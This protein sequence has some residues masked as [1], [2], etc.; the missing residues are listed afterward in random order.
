MILSGNALS[1][2]IARRL[3]SIAGVLIILTGAVAATVTWFEEKRGIEER[4]TQLAAS[5]AASLAQTIWLVDVSQMQ[6]QLKGIA[7]FPGVSH[8]AVHTF[9]GQSFRS[10]HEAGD[11]GD[12]FAQ[13]TVPLLH[14]EQ[15]IGRLEL[16]ISRSALI[17]RVGSRLWQIILAQL[18]LLALDAA[19]LFYFVRRDASLP[20]K[21][22]AGQLHNFKPDAPALTLPEDRRQQADEL[23]DLAASFN[24]MQATIS[25]KIDD[26]RRL[27]REL[28]ASH[29]RLEDLAANRQRRLNYL[30]GFGQ[31]VLHM[32]S[33]FI[34][35]PLEA[36]EPEV[37]R[38]LHEVAD[39]I[40][41]DCVV[42]VE[43]DAQGYQRLRA[44]T[45]AR[46]EALAAADETAIAAFGHW[47]S[48]RLH[49]RQAMHHEALSALQGEEARRHAPLTALAVEAIFSVP[50][51]ARGRSHGLLICAS[52]GR[53]RV[54]QEQELDLLELV[55][56]ITASALMQRD[57]LRDLDASHRKL[58]E[59]NRDL[60]QLARTDSLTGLPNRREFNDA[61][62]RE[63]ARSLRSH[64]PLSL[65]LVDLDYFKAYNDSLGHAEGDVCLSAFAALL[66]SISRRPADLPVRLGGEEFGLLLPATDI[67]G[68]EERGFAL[69]KALAQLGLRHPASPLGT[70]LTASIGIAQFD[71]RRHPRFDD[72]YAEADAALYAA[73]AGG[74]DCI[75]AGVP[76]RRVS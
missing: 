44:C 68:A 76:P 26:E 5:H 42:I 67:R 53:P 6:E 19:V 3:A 64:E 29:D 15:A 61:W 60:E 50:L 69:Q 28:A 25:R 59:A 12:S 62:Q 10:E 18:L 36:F 45:A 30:E 70:M 17:Q 11:R 27:R 63:M 52:F 9:I 65:L 32:S 14:E 43:A 7:R 39:H 31:L 13:L 20:I 16:G 72:L 1:Q 54:W 46:N 37:E 41:V 23:A 55:G 40:A 48:L 38:R 47:V 75:M 24:R 58:E 35:L 49:S 8:V 2:R 21:D 4:L 34:N 33:G 57:V 66:R 56:Q 51:I 73:K 22:L 71:S 74:R